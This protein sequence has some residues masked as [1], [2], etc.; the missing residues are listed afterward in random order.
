MKKQ[1]EIHGQRVDL[2]SLDQ[3]RTW[4]SSPQSIIACKEREAAL[5]LELQERFERINWMQDPGPN[6]IAKLSGIRR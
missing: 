5:R 2:Y 4:A 3:G 6:N 1:I